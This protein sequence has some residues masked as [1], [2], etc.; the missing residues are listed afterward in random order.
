MRKI[1]ALLPLVLLLAGCAPQELKVD[2][3]GST[4]HPVVDDA[5]GRTYSAEGAGPGCHWIVDGGGYERVWGTE[6]D[7]TVTFLESDARLR[8][9]GQ[10][11]TWVLVQ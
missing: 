5:V 10:C 1:L 6:E 8:D 9:N 2:P 3:A 7:A 11:G 4:I